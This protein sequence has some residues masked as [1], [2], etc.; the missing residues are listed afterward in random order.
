MRILNKTETADRLPW[1]PLREALRRIF[2]EGCEAPLRHSHPLP[3]KDAAEGTLLLM[4]AWQPH[5]FTGVKIVHVN[6][7]NA[8]SPGM[9]A[10][11][12]VYLLSDGESGQPLCMLDG[13]M[14]T[15]RRTAAASVLAAT[16]LARPE[17]SRLLLLGSG[18]VAHALA[19]AYAERF[20]LREVRVWSRRPES[21][22]RLA[23]I[24]AESGLPAHAVAEPDPAGADIVTAA[25]L[26]TTPLFDGAAV[27]PGTHVDLVGAFR[28]DM[29]ESDSTLVRRARLFV[30]T[31]AGALAEAG[32]VVQAIVEGAIDAGHIQADL[33]DLCRGTH[34]GRREAEEITL[35]KSVGW[36]GEDLAAAVLA[37]QAA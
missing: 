9:Q 1:P 16:Y 17:S 33:F 12:S 10:V 32:D 21:A 6:P 18:K 20:P 13:S 5:R 26:S 2:E 31:R 3:Q 24:L 7:S 30:D 35:F 22:A 34:L 8:R 25:T 27:A 14:L 36:A 4:P 28:R 19:E 29:R 11:H 37:Y 23:R 15:D